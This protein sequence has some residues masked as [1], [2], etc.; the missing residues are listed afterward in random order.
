MDLLNGGDL[1]YHICRHRRFTE[2]QTSKFQRNQGIG[3]FIACLVAGLEYIHNKNIIH[4]DIKPENLVLDEE[5]TFWLELYRLRSNYRLRNCT[6]LE[7]WQRTRYFWHSRL[8]G[9][10]SNVSSKSWCFSRLFCCRSDGLWVH[11]WKS[12]YLRLILQ[13]PYVG[14]SRKEIR[15]HILSKQIQIKRNEIPRGWSV[16]AA[17]FINKVIN[18]LTKT[19]DSKETIKQ[20]W[21]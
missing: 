12:K 21:T 11:V 13:R 7:T 6:N 9:S 4:R 14:K 10:R 5:G 18:V 19:D 2:E 20:T 17:D 3:F 15:D 16:E 1:R 8:H